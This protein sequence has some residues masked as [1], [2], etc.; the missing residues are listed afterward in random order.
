V[1]RAEG[2]PG[3][4]PLN[5]QEPTGGKKPK[6]P[7][8]LKGV[9]SKLW[10]DLVR[11]FGDMGIL[12]RADSLS[13]ELMCECYKEWRTATDFIEAKGAVYATTNIKGDKLL[14]QVPQVAQAADAWRRLRSLISEFGMTPSSRVRLGSVEE[15]ENELSKLMREM[16]ERRKKQAQQRN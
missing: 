7:K 13:L 6:K 8:H 12:D 9:S 2:N 5:N 1:K 16:A 15:E 11:L 3:K 14:R 10:N 4:R